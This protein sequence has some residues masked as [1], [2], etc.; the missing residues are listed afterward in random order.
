MKKEKSVY[1]NYYDY[2]EAVKKI[3]GHRIL[4]INRG[5]KEKFLIVRIEAPEEKI[6]R[7]LEKKVIHRDDSPMSALLRSVVEDSYHR[8]IGPAIEREVRS[9]LTERAEDGGIKV[10][11]KNLERF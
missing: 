8:L 7:Y 9:E 10:F 6:L 4:A 2:E 5:E 11:G 3:P 1:E